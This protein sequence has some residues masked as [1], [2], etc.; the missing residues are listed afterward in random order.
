[1]PKQKAVEVKKE[2]LP[3]RTLGQTTP[4]PETAANSHNNMNEK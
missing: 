4:P 1:M 2:G 3:P